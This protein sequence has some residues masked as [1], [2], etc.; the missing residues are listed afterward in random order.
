MLQVPE[1]MDTDDTLYFDSFTVETH[2]KR[3]MNKL[4]R[5]IAILLAPHLSKNIKYIAS[6]AVNPVSAYTMMKHF[7]A[8]P[9]DKYV[10]YIE[11]K[12]KRRWMKKKVDYMDLKRITKFMEKKP[13]FYTYIDLFDLNNVKN[14]EN[15]VADILKT[16]SIKCGLSHLSKS[17]SKSNQTKGT[18]VKKSR[19]GKR[20]LTRRFTH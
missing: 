4:L 1:T 19:G 6:P 14:A 3:N 17:K 9:E 11:Q 5:A 13:Y 8:I 2:Q 10:K 18:R 16:N 20:V 7:N 15:I 12:S